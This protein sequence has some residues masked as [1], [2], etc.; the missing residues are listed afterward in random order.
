MKSETMSDQIW[1]FPTKFHCGQ[2]FLQT[3]LTVISGYVQWTV[4][5]EG[6][7]QFESEDKMVTD[8]HILGC[9]AS[10]SLPP[11]QHSTIV[12]G[13]KQYGNHQS[14]TETCTQEF[15]HKP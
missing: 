5:M 7:F 1:K 4:C 2:T 3:V 8:E 15:R 14:R 6:Q 11:P 12:Y 9:P 10:A 13:E